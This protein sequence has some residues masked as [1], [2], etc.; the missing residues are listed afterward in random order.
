MEKKIMIFDALDTIQGYRDA[1]LGSSK[2]FYQKRISEAAGMNV[3]E[4]LQKVPY[5]VQL[6]LTYFELQKGNLE[7]IMLP[8]ADEIIGYVKSREIKP[9]IVTADIPKSAEIATRPFIDA[10]LIDPTN[11]YAIN[12]VG[13]KKDPQTWAKIKEQYF[14]NEKIVGVFEDTQA[15]LQAALESYVGN[16]YLVKQTDSSLN[17]VSPRIVKGNL[18]HLMGELERKLGEN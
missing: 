12:Y 2:Q 4:F 3:D 13:I 18:F 6:W 17:I 15:N 10:G 8:G 7:P 9:I 5:D 16:G 14:D 11:I 1:P